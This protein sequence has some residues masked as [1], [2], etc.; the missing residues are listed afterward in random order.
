MAIVLDGTSGATL[1]VP[2]AVAQGGTGSTTLTLTSPVIA[3]TPTG[4]GTLTSGTAVASTSGTY[5][6]FTGI[7]SWVKR[8]TVMFNGIS[9]TT[10]GTAGSSI[11]VQ[12]GYSGGFLTSTY[13][14]ATTAMG[15]AVVTTAYSNGFMIETAPVTARTYQGVMT[16][17]NITGN[18]WCELHTLG[19]SDVAR[20]NTGAGFATLSG[21]LTQIRITTQSGTDTFDAG[22]I[23]IMYE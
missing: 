6:D 16:L 8:I 3:G 4:V 2:L 23:N 21:V 5:I 1:P 10:G 13:L 11:I 18:G 12:I 7:P 19:N 9:V 17:A 14:G 15:A 20:C 22:S